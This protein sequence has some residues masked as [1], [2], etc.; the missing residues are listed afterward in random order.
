LL[1][2]DTGSIGK[3]DVK[4]VPFVEL[5]NNRL[6]GVVS[7]GS[8]IARVYVSYFECRTLNYSCSTNNNRPCGGLRG[9]PC[10]H[11]KE[12]LGEA[13]AQY[14]FDRV[15]Q[16]LQIPGDAPQTEHAIL[17]RAG[18]AHSEF[19]ADIFSRF[20]SD[21]ELLELPTSNAPISTMAWFGGGK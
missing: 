6:Q 14:G 16:F 10:N 20:L 5:F 21:L 13:V 12:L 18:R 11:L 2:T 17:S 19:A 1:I 3:R 4:K 15:V 7:S 8:D 9:S